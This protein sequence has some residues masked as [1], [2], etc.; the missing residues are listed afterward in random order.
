[1]AR[2]QPPGHDAP[3]VPFQIAVSRRD[4]LRAS[5]RWA[6][7]FAALGSGWTL[8]SCSPA[9]SGGVTVQATPSAKAPPAAPP[10]AAPAGAPAAPPTPAAAAP[11]K[12]AG[13]APK[14]GGTLTLARDTDAN[15]LYP[16]MNSGLADIATNFLLY[17]ALMLHDFGG[18][19]QPLLAERWD[20]SGDGLTWTFTLKPNVKFHS[21]EPFT[22]AHVKDHFDRWLNP[23]NKFPTRAKIASLESVQVLDD[24]KVA[25]KLKGPTLVFQTNISQTEWA[26]ASIPNM[27]A[28]AQAGP[29]YGIKV[30]DGTGPFKLQEWIKDDRLTLVR[31]DAY[32]WGS[33]AYENTGPAFVDKL[34][35]RIIPEAASRSAELETGGV[36]LDIAVS[37]K[38]VERL[39]A[40]PNLTITS[41]PRVSSNHIGFNL[42]REMFQDVRVR[43]AITHGVNREQ[44]ARFVMRGQADP[45]EGY[46]HPSLPEASP[47]EQTRPHV[48]FDPERSKQLLD[49]AGWKVGAGGVR[50]KDGKPLSF[51]VYVSNEQD[52]QINTAVQAQLKEIGV[53]MRIRR[54]ETG[55]FNEATRAGEHDARFI[56]MIYTTPDH[57]YFFVG[58]SIPTPN[59]IRW[60]DAEYDELFKQSQTTTKP[61]ER[62]EA[63]RKMEMR[64]LEQAVVVP[65]QHLKW[66]FGARKRV[67]GQ[68]FHPIQGIYKL[69]DTWVE[70]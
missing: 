12:A 47:R 1:M 6:G 35:I 14:R 31:H 67:Q 29:D 52:E 70:G 34:V 44:V 11:A 66:I 39:Q 58:E 54:L 40:S 37:P 32:T 61:E 51:T 5:A 24:L 41:F 16:G 49:E 21:G 46:L 33:P 43:R 7:L 56:P 62:T 68:K 45:A 19:I 9:P 20:V 48:T 10:T 65:I 59:T 15:S 28:V 18:K 57:M 42:E 38:D 13:P 8:V 23:E 60:R 53:D 25:F 4:F 30:V 3:V 50:E 69:M 26:Y 27:K 64:M 63:F 36:D 55:A 2:S 22:A 17:D